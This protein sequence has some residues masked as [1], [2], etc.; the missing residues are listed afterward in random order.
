MPEACLHHHLPL[1]LF[2]DEGVLGRSSACQ[3]FLRL[4]TAGCFFFLARAREKPHQHP[5]LKGLVGH[6][7][8]TGII[9]LLQATYQPFYM[10]LVIR[11]P[12]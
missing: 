10:N 1:H 5:V 7:L 12:G 2:V 11:Q 4:L 3:H 6:I 9:S 8:V